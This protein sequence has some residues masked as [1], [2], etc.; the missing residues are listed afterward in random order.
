MDDRRAVLIVAG[1]TASGKTPL[2]IELARRFD[3]EIVG[4]DSRQ[5]YRGMPI[6][7][8]APSPEQL[9]AIPHHCVGLVDPCER[10]SAA[11]YVGD[12]LAAIDAIHQRGKRAIVVGGTGFYLRAL[13]GAV[14]LAPAYDERLRNRLHDEARM[15]PPE[16][17]HQWL[18]LLDARRAADL[19]A[20]DTYRILRGL[21]IALARDARERD[22]PLRTLASEGITW[23]TIAL[24][25][26]LTE[27][28][29]RIEQRC[30]AMLRAGFVEE[31]ERIG[32]AAPAASAVGY[33][34]ALAYLRG[35]GTS[36][37]LRALLIRATKRYARRQRAWFRRERGVLWLASDTAADVA[38]EKLGWL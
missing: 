17:L 21:E 26:A 22:G 6:G 18:A 34:Q 12:A 11:R 20:R 23:I 25:V 1:P 3:A 4:A 19:D 8:A 13:V 30:A 35:W 32:E 37:E 15:H 16:F 38:R 10:Y 24:D 33:P 2:A 28:D 5:I 31:A 9:A 14:E 29:A 36:S 7:T 27:L